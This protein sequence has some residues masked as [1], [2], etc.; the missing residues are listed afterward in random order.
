MI[1]TARDVPA[2]DFLIGEL[3]RRGYDAGYPPSSISDGRLAAIVLVTPT[4]A[5]D[6][7]AFP[8][9]QTCA[10]EEAL[11]VQPVIAVRYTADPLPLFAREL[12]S[13]DARRK[14]LMDTA[15]AI[16]AAVRELP[17]RK[18]EPGYTPHP[19]FRAIA[20]VF[21][22]YASEDHRHAQ[23]LASRLSESGYRPWLDRK[24]ILPGSTW[25]SEIRDAIRESVA[26]VACL[27]RR[28]QAS[29]ERF[30]QEELRIALDVEDS[31]II[32]LRLDDCEVPKEL[33]R[34]QWVDGI[35]AESFSRLT[36]ALDRRLQT[37]QRKS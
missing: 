7:I 9:F 12:P 29:A 16:D 10:S 13:I 17:V 2:G 19:A 30:V 23:W 1:C 20:P 6:E 3:R 32:P 33:S 28:W 18:P 27:S 11:E 8:L 4:L 36:R 34:F 35:D 22:S 14:P 21:I 25:D 37:K 5:E 24:D 26:F 15:A 31:F